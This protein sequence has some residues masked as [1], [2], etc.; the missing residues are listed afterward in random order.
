M[1]ASGVSQLRFD[2]PGQQNGWVGYTELEAVGTPSNGNVLPT[3]TALSIAA[4]S[5]L[6]LGGALQQVAAL[7]DFSPGVSGAVINSTT[8]AISLLTFAPAGG[9]SVFSGAISGGGTL[10]A[11]AL[12][13]NGPGTQVLAGSNTYTGPTTITAGTLQIGNGGNSGTIGT[14][15]VAI[16]DTLIFS[17]SDAGLT[18][19]SVISGSG[20]VYQKGSGLTTLTGNNTFSGPATVSAGTLQIGNGTSGN[21]GSFAPA[22]IVN[23]STLKY[24]TAVGELYA[25]A[26]SGSGALNKSGTGTLMLS[27][28]NT[29]GGATT[30]NGGTLRLVPPVANVIGGSKL[31]LNAAGIVGIANGGTVSVVQDLSGNANNTS[32]GLGAVT[33]STTGLNNNPTMVFNG[34]SRLNDPYSASGNTGTIFVVIKSANLT[35]TGSFFG[36][37]GS[38]GIEFRQQGANLD[39]LRQGVNDLT[40]TNTSPVTTSTQ[41]VA[42]TFNQSTGGGTQF[43]NNGVLQTNGIIQNNF[44]AFTGGRTATIGSGNANVEF[45]SGDIS[46]V[47][48]YNTILT[49][50][51]IAATTAALNNQFSGTPPAVYQVLPTTTDLSINTSGAGLDLA[52]INQSLASL[53]GAAGSFVRL[54]GA[55]LAVGSDNLTTTF[56]GN[57]TDAGG[58]SPA[59]GG[60]LTK[61]GAGMFTLTGA[62]NYSGATNISG[63][64]L[65]IG[66]AGVLGGGNYSGAISNSGVLAVNTSSNQTYGGAISGAG[67]LYQLGSGTL[68][69]AAN[70]SYAGG[71]FINGGGLVVGNGGTAGSI[72]SAG[73][74]TISNNGALASNRSDSVTWD[75]AINGTGSL[76]QLG[77]GTLTLTAN[78]GYSGATTV[79]AGTLVL[80]STGANNIAASSLVTVNPAATLDVTGLASGGITLAGG[81]T[82]R[83]SGT[84]LGSITAP[85]GATIQSGTGAATG[86]GIGTLTLANDL[87]VASGA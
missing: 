85:S 72:L 38:G 29:Y 42:V 18:V 50:D 78:N 83:G 74:N 51:Q 79:A 69:L 67:P 10:G 11:I 4:T 39:F 86:T 43:Y 60:A 61:N 48:A 34:A 8:G 54:G 58:A 65:Q 77:S 56:A 21:D 15:S 49:P 84:V 64:T 5:T 19:A 6:D 44:T 12:T 62:N 13:M 26:I 28:S 81:Q 66:G 36:A 70:N 16:N 9:S 3:S 82:L 32:A 22:S 76:Y 80:S 45:F 75:A 33:F 17:R 63:G 73:S 35:Q 30:I 46:A 55:A 68:T 59:T 23:N 7:G 47:V 14:G 37:S 57:I 41:V 40:N 53:S 1:L 87:S 25:G 2:F 27:G 24:N 52:S 31:Y 20:A 71:T